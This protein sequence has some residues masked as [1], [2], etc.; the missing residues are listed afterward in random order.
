MTVYINGS[1]LN[2]TEAIPSTP[3]GLDKLRFDLGQGSSKFFGNTKDLQVFDKALSD[4]QLKQLT[5]I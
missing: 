1:I 3:T 4:Y 5:T 2:T